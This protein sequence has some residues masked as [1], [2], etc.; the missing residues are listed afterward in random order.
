MVNACGRIYV[1]RGGQ[2]DQTDAAVRRTRRTCC[3]IIDKIVSR[4]R[5]AASTR[6]ARWSTPACPTARRVNA[7]IPPLAL[8]GPLLTIRKFS[9]DPFTVEDLVS[10][11][12]LTEPRRGVPARP[13]CAVG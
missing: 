9:D 13:A 11:G 4:R 10:F 1:E 7:I 5:A 12:T 8:D 6:P 3:A 2:I